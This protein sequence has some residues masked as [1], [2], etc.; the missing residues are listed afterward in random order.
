MVSDPKKEQVAPSKPAPYD[1][2]ADGPTRIEPQRTDE[3]NIVTGRAVTG[4]PTSDGDSESWNPTTLGR[5]KI[6]GT[7]GKGGFGTVYLGFDDRLK[8]KVAIKVPTR[9]LTDIALDQFLVEAQRLAQLRHS[10]IVT[11]FDVGEAEGRCYIVSDYLEGQS[12]SKWMEGTPYSWA[13]A[14]TI[15]AQL[16]DALAHAHASG[17][18]HRDLK[19]SN[20]MMLANN[21]PVLIDFGLAISDSDEGERELPG[22]IA[23]TPSYMSPEQ[24]A[25]RAHRIDGRTDIYSLGVM[26]YHLLCRKRPFRSTNVG[27]LMRQIREDEPQPLR[28]VVPDI[29]TELEQVCLKAMAKRTKDRFTTAADLASALRQVILD[30][31]PGLDQS[32]NPQ[33]ESHDT[34]SE[35]A[36]QPRSTRHGLHE[37]ERRQITTLCLVFDDSEMDVEDAD[38]ETF[39]EVVQRFQEVSNRVFVRY[40]GHLA[41]SSS[42][43]IQAYF[44]YPLAFEDSSR[45]AVMAGLDIAAEIQKLQLRS[46]KK[47]ETNVDFRIGIHTGIMITEEVDSETP[48]SR[49]THS[50]RHSFVGN[51]PK[52]AAGLADIAEPGGIWVSAATAQIVG[53]S[54]IFRSIGTH[55]GKAIGRNVELFAVVGRNEESGQV[56]KSAA[57]QAPLVGREHEM[58]LLN[59]RWQQ[60]A[61]GLGQVVLLSA[62][63]GV[64]KSRLM[65]AFRQRLDTNSFRAIDTGCSAY[66]QNTAFYPVSQLL[67]KLARFEPGDSDEAKLSKLECLF[68][69]W[70]IPLE[71]VIPLL[72]DL[73]GIPLGPLYA[74][75]EGTPERRKQKTIEALIELLLVVS[76]TQ[77]V[78]LT[79]EDLHWI[80]PSTLQFLTMFIEQI[81]AAP[82]FLLLTYRPSFVVPWPTRPSLVS[83]A[84]GNLTAEQTT[85]VVTRIAGRKLPDEVFSHIVARTGGVPLFTE[86][87]TKVILESGIL[88]E[89]GDEYRLVRP[90]SSI[91]IPSTL[92]DSLMARLDNLGAA[93]EVAQLASVIGREF[94]FQLL[95]A[96]TPLD[97][98]TLQAELTSLVNA[99]LVH[100]RGFFP[101]AR[102]TFKHALVQDTAYESLLRKTRQQWHGRIADVLISRATQMG[103]SSPELLAHH[104]TEAGHTVEAISYWSKAG[105]QAQE[106]SANNEAISHFRQGLALVETLDESTERDALEFQF[107]VPLGVA[108]LTTQGYA[109]PEVGPVFERA[110]MFGQKLTEPAVQFHIHWGIWAW[111]VV[112]EELENCSQMFEEAM[113]LIEPLN[114]PGLRVE[115]LF[116]GVLTSFY[117]GEFAKTVE[118]CEQGFPL[119]DLETSKQHA[120]HTGQ[121]VGATMQSYWALAL[122]HLGYPEQAIDR[123]AQ[124]V[125]LARSLKHPFSLAYALCHA[126]WL[127]HHCR[128]REA[129]EKFSQEEIV[130]STEQSF[131]FWLA[132]GY[133]HKGFAALLAQDGTE[134][135]ES[136]QTGLTIFNMTGANLSLC[137]FQAQI[138][139]GLSLTGHS[140]AALQ[141]IDEALATSAINGNV[142]NLAEIHRLRGEILLAHFRDNGTEAEASFKKSL[143]IARAQQA[144][145][146]ELRTLVSLHRL[147]KEQGRKSESRA[148]L[149]SVYQWF[150]EGHDLPDLTEAK[151]LLEHAD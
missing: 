42:E 58:N 111:R 22:T 128:H 100:Q 68:K 137:Q 21:Q 55:S 32:S 36:G 62:E 85:A 98:D 48:Q 26:L 88:E 115:A 113:E 95:A 89:S 54:F 65:N 60:A 150:Q 145:S 130:L 123:A 63:A 94:T 11:V 141:K 78:L 49:S 122:W 110:R 2:S 144:R 67:K 9:V 127:H 66:Q 142:F 139:L 6:H 124:A 112:R 3:T 57:N 91:T 106:R 82:I 20:V 4:T 138:A 38:P 16:A 101:R 61:S 131:P 118:L 18:V 143:E 28:Q 77:P 25:G 75:L 56:E 1:D 7:L 149:E 99:D 23:G 44:G 84:L 51:V 90:L 30:A 13:Q 33:S 117:R 108:L 74:A 134:G 104:Y 116:I 76:E 93:K 80:D 71:P 92:Q 5:F 126:S 83:L 109:A 46:R 73:V 114:N 17:T 121:N 40:G 72:V 79:I 50:A 59:G 37:A 24:A 132:E 107:L 53:D 70:D 151:Q 148:A 120:R 102:F 31:G 64:G 135:L 125:A 19:P 133:F 129:V 39:R 140:A 12:L 147:H 29:P 14:T 34:E 69:R 52:V 47:A 8:R 27:E 96:I 105:L 97:A 86:E 45:R 119:F 15:V 146:S 136:L 43:S 103:E 41:Q 87:L 10:G 35:S 81:P